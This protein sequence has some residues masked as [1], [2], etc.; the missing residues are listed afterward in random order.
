MRAMPNRLFTLVLV[1]I[2]GCGRKSPNPPASLLH[3]TGLATTHLPSCVDARCGDGE[4]PPLGGAHCPQPLPCSVY[5]TEQPRCAWVHNL[6]HGH[7]VL[8][9]NC[10]EGCADIVESLSAIREA[11]REQ[12]QSRIVIT[13]DPQLPGRV[14]AIVWGWGWVGNEVNA[15]L[16]EEVLSHQDIDSPEAG[17]SCMQ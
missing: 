3:R 10:P 17:L 7:A 16:F 11:K 6:E 8:A 14:A 15:D 5:D 12:G 2:F 9:Y 13:P 1:L 4:N